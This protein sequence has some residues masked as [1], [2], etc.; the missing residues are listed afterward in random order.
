MNY[1]GAKEGAPLEDVLCRSF[2]A[3]AEQFGEKIETELK[4]GGKDI[5]V[6]EENRA[7]FLELF[8]DFQFRK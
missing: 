3:D 8:I 2:V 7:E 4:P 5:L 1:D 6:T